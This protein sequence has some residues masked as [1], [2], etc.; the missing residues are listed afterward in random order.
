MKQPGEA[1]TPREGAQGP[2]RRRNFLGRQSEG[3][4]RNHNVTES[5]HNVH[6]EQYEGTQ[7]VQNQRQNAQQAR[8]TMDKEESWRRPWGSEQRSKHEQDVRIQT[9][10]VNT[11]P[12]RGT[13]KMT[14]LRKVMEGATITGLIEINKNHY[15]L[16]HIKGIGSSIKQWNNHSK[17]QIEWI[18][19][20]DW[21]HE[22]QQGGQHHKPGRREGVF[23]K[24]R[25]GQRRAWKMVVDDI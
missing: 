18:R 15:K 8:T 6:E 2:T 10:N 4:D 13:S 23:P 21:Q 7:R 24:F 25:R 14:M 19:D 22:Y 9:I 16:D 3:R 5:R 17:T 1:P 12:R 20:R 11:F